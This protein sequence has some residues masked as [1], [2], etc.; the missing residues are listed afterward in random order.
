MKNE[1]DVVAGLG[2]IGMPI[3]KLL[4]RSGI[5]IGYDINHNLMNVKQ[6]ELH[7]SLNTRLL[8]ICIP[9][10][11]QFV[12]QV[13]S[14]YRKF[15]PKCVIIHSTVSPYTTKTLQEKIDMPVICS[16]TRGIH[17]QMLSDL[18]KYVKYFATE[19]NAPN[20]LWATRLY[21][22]TMKQCGI[23]TKPMSEPIVLELAKILVDTSY[24]GW[25]INYAQLS[26]MIA[27]QHNV[28]Y[29]EMWSFADDMQKYRPKMFP[30][31]IG[32]HCV[33][34]NLDLIHNETLNMIREI[35]DMYIKKNPDAKLINKRYENFKKH[36]YDA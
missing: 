1:K 9:F 13:M 19:K 14:L 10:S 4:S 8:H 21:S 16:P 27:I 17:R 6:F 20:R 34:P 15:L 5:V 18:K 23:K 25:L 35:N 36:S 11:N 24:Y 7:S 33:I 29:D 28:N 3:F 31:F 22:S 32:G 26:N 12:T 30:G 2:E